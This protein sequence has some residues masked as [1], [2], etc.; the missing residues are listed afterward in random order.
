MDPARDLSQLSQEN[1]RA[2]SSPGPDEDWFQTYFDYKAYSQNTQAYSHDKSSHRAT[3]QDLDRIITGIPDIL[4][5]LESFKFF[6]MGAPFGS[7]DGVVHS[8]YSGQPSTPDLVLGEGST[9]PSDH[10]GPT[11]PD[12]IEDPVPRSG[13]SLIDVKAQDDKWTYPNTELSKAARRAYP[14]KLH[15][16]PDG[17]T[18]STEQT[19][20]SAGTKRRRSE[21]VPEKRARQLADREQT[22]DVRKS[23]ACLPCRVS[24]T[25]VRQASLFS[26][27]F[28]TCTKAK[29]MSSATTMVY[30][31]HAERPSRSTP[32]WSA[33][34]CALRKPGQSSREPMVGFQSVGS[35]H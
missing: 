21:K 26:P 25:R 24:K 10:S 27:V 16:V 23:G 30:V 11:F 2:P 19:A 29:T 6:R 3:P 13:A 32:I 35:R 1:P 20:A 28:V 12:R 34:A 7:D 33:H 15:V 17:P 9:S 18:K 22:A 8:D 14:P 5:E 31:P 4:D